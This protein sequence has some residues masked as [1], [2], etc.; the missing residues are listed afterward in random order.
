[1]PAASVPSSRRT[2]GGAR[3]GAGRKPAAAKPRVP[4]QRRPRLSRHHPVHVTLRLAPGLPNLRTRRFGRVLFA[5]FAAARARFA[6]RLTHFSI[7]SNHL[8]LVVEAA[9]RRA[10]SRGLQGLAIRVAKRVNARVGRRGAVFADRYFARALRT[11]LDV[12]RTLLYVMNNYRRHNRVGAA[13]PP[14]DWADPYSSVDHFDGFAELPSGRTPCAELSLGR[15]PPV[16]PAVTWLLKIGW[17]RLGLLHVHHVP[18]SAPGPASFGR[19]A[20]AP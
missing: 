1:M 20:S 9:D 5:A 15:D 14:R 17:K 4:H 16:A 3:P 6:V 7:Q 13:H 8:H 19:R 18:G 11:P 12:R 2:W 10:L